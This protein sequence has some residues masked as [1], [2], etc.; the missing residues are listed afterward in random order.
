MPSPPPDD[1]SARETALKGNHSFIVQ[2]PAG[3]GKT[4]LLVQ[5]ILSLLATTVSHPGEILAITFTRKAAFEMQQRVYA[6]LQ[7]T[8]SPENAARWQP[9][10]QAL[11]RQVMLRDQ[12]YGWRLLRD[13]AL[14]RIQTIDGFCHSIAQRH[15]GKNALAVDFSIA[16][17]ASIFYREATESVVYALEHSPPYL[18]ALCCALEY[19][20]NQPTRLVD[21]LT[22]MLPLREQWLGITLPF[23]QSAPAQSAAVLRAQW[24]SYVTQ[25][26]G[27]LNAHW[28]KDERKRWW[29][30]ANSIDDTINSPYP[31]TTESKDL[32]CWQAL[33]RLLLTQKNQWRKRPTVKKAHPQYQACYAALQAAK[34]H[35]GL[36]TLLAEILTLPT[37]D[38]ITGE[39]TIVRAFVVLLHY[40]CAEL[41]LRFDQ[42]RVY[43]YS[44]VQNAAIAALE[45]SVCYDPNCGFE[46]RIRHV[47]VDE[48]QDTSHHQWRLLQALVREWSNDG[49]STLFL[50][51]DPMQSIY[52]FRQA[53]VRLFAQAWEQ[54]RLGPL[55][56][57]R[58]RLTRNFRSHRNLVSTLN[59]YFAVT[60]PADTDF[61]LA[62]IPY[63]DSIATRELAI[64]P[65]VTCLPCAIAA[66]TYADAMTRYTPLIKAIRALLQDNPQAEIALL[67]RQ[68]TH[69]AT[70]LETLRAQGITCCAHELD[71]LDQKQ[72]VFDLISL[73]SALAQPLD[74]L[75][76]LSCLRAPWCGLTLEDLLVIAHSAQPTIWQALLDATT[77]AQLSADGK[78][79]VTFLTTVMVPFVS[80]YGSVAIVEL[81]DGCWRALHGDRCLRGAE[82]I[83]VEQFFAC[84]MQTH[85][86]GNLDLP[87]LQSALARHR[88]SDSE[89]N[90]V[91]VMTMHKAKG[92]EFDYVFLV[93]LERTPGSGDPPP[94]RFYAD[95]HHALLAARTLSGHQQTGLYSYLKSLEQRQI[96]HETRRLFYVACTRARLRLFLHM[97][98]KIDDKGEYRPPAS[99]SLLAL[100]WPQLRH[101][102][103]APSAMDCTEKSSSS[104]ASP[105]PRPLRR[106]PA[107]DL[108]L[109]A[110]TLNIVDQEKLPYAAA[111]TLSANDPMK[112]CGILAHE[113][114]AWIVQQRLCTNLRD[115]Q[116]LADFLAA[117]RPRWQRELHAAGNDAAD[118]RGYLEIIIQTL[119]NTLKDARGYWLLDYRH[120]GSACEYALLRQ[121]ERLVIDRT[122][123]DDEDVRWVVDYK[124]TRNPD[125][126]GSHQRWVEQ[127]MAYGRAFVHYKPQSV[128]CALYYPL[129][130][131]WEEVEC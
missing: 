18:D 87:A 20:D 51:G 92:L 55:P 24:N 40:A 65:A 100:W 76:W 96:A 88:V 82:A 85:N 27:T 14:L 66:H 34:S 70:L 121:G 59:D 90:N 95:T 43:D 26:L 75:A 98:L 72:V 13:P 107:K 128:R 36:E 29:E 112:R 122:F 94:L 111:M 124:I 80:R 60:F 21:T 115:D 46:Q 23:T 130:M 78:Q 114:L 101:T 2:A 49:N 53:D 10:S 84:L 48:F 11:A 52:R 106:L 1:H 4:E 57:T 127:L 63:K 15:G 110:T 125:A 35:P 131:R 116:K 5:R 9:R 113:A 117:W 54:Q 73:A 41:Q 71:T 99:G 103:P 68:R 108:I 19:F 120:S 58:L 61:R 77:C 12:Q 44:A 119:R 104:T 109:P 97:T 79:R 86:S 126:G 93:D 83:Q 39:S 118:S 50:V 56:L 81:L 69:A 28:P 38:G 32:P 89:A 67:L 33:A 8:A 47:L 37:E 31:P 74:R 22:Q 30:V 102:L 64:D 62:A 16:E 6:I 129:Q 7:D 105:P 42:Q 45:N 25:L 91:Q 3:A 123:M 17:D